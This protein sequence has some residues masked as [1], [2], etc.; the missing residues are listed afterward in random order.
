MIM[1]ALTDNAPDSWL[2]VLGTCENI[3]GT[4]FEEI[5]EGRERGRAWSIH[6]WTAYENPHMKRQWKAELSEMIGSNPD[7]IHASW[8]KTHYLNEWCADDDLLIIPAKKLV[9]VKFVD[10]GTYNYVLAVDL[11][12][13]DANSFTV[14]AFSERTRRAVIVKSFKEAE[15]DF[16]DV[17]N[18]I[19]EIQRKY[20]IYKIRI[21][22]ANKQGVEEIK[23]RHH[24]PMEA[25][26]KTD[27]A[28]YLRLIRDD[29]LTGTLVMDED[30]C[31]ELY[32]EWTQLMWKD[33]DRS[34]EDDRCQNHC[35]DSAL[36]AWRE[37]RH[38]LYSPPAD[39][40]S[41]DTDDYMTDLEMREG[42]KMELEEEDSF[43]GIGED[44]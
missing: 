6:K 26:E 35:S 25:A 1:P 8:F 30:N 36:Y 3:P 44:W 32:S 22:G 18:K 11:G 29:V 13:N 42:E 7:I 15:L 37:C 4:F 38:Y 17:A 33:S 20:N 9:K 12:Y 27:K 28:I 43:L 2:S 40:P 34:K 16:T 19:K 41:R 24:I 5:T 23:K 31:G 10:D 21:D 14:V 39:I